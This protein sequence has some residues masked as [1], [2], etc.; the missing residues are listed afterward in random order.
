MGSVQPFLLQ[1][2][3]IQLSGDPAEDACWVNG[4]TIDILVDSGA[5]FSTVITSVGVS[6]IPIAEPLSHR[7]AAFF[8]DIWW[9][10][11]QF[12]GK[13]FTWQIASCFSLYSG[14]MIRLLKPFSSYNLQFIVLHC[15][16]MPGFNILPSFRPCCRLLWLLCVILQQHLSIY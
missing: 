6:G 1:A 9:R 4:S 14:W 2:V 11:H 3:T 8:S 15:W 10:S 16:T 13:R 5:I 7:C 12:D